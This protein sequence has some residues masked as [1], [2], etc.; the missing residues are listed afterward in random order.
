MTS[1]ARLAPLALL[2]LPGCP[3]LLVPD[4]I[5]STGG[6]G[7]S[8]ASATS[9]ATSDATTG[10]PGDPTTTTGTTGDEPGDPTTPGTSVS[11]ST[12]APPPAQCDFP[13]SIE[14]IFAAC[15]CH[16]GG[17]PPA[18]LVLSEGQA[19]ASLVGVASTQLPDALRVDPGDAAASWLVTKL[20]PMPPVGDTMPLGGALAPE[21]LAR[22]EAWIDAGAPEAGA[23]ACDGEDG[24]GAGSVEISEPGPVQVDVGELVDLDALVLDG[25]G[26]PVQ[27]ATVVWKSDAEATLFVDG[28]GTLLGLAPGSAAVTA[29]VDGIVS[30][31]LVVEVTVND[32]PAAP[33][34]DVLAVLTSRCGCHGGDMPAAGLSF[35]TGAEAVHAA[36]LM[37]STQVPEVLRV[38]KDAPGQS[39]LF[40]KLTRAA[41]TK[42]EPMP[43]GK[44]P[45]E[46]E[47]VQPI[48][49]WIL[50][51][52]PL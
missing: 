25:Q 10:G 20:K 52:A 18:G 51:G 41:P 14:P 2:A 11:G 45:L 28:K 16:D 21:D 4:D 29:E 44:G 47:K 12:G 46:A 13:T 39:Y 42:G 43:K 6:A 27:G 49:W 35:S 15:G 50:N 5:D 23:F 38:A 9:S 32:P 26:A 31:P 30:A 33:F 24:G 8:E 1:A 34:A 36:L 40:Q 3:I 19:F 37:P 7:S 17:M 48:L 22:I